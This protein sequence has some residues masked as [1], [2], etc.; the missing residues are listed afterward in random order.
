MVQ[1][2]AGTL[3]DTRIVD[4][5]LFWLKGFPDRWRL[6]EVLWRDKG[7]TERVT[8]ETRAASAAA[9]DTAAARAQAPVVGRSRELEVVTQQLLA[10][11]S[12][13][14][15]AVV[16]EG[17]AG[18]GKTRMLE[19]TA[20]LATN[21]EQQFWVLDVSADEELQGPFLLFRSLLSSP[22]MATVAREAVAGEQ[23]DAALE[24][25][26]GR[27]QRLEGL[28]PQEQMLRT[29][30]EVATTILTLTRE[31]PLLLMLDDLQWADDDSIQLIRYLVRTMG[32]A[33]VFILISLRPYSDSATGG[34]SKL[35]ADLDRMRV[36][37][38]L[39]LQR[40]TQRES[41]ELLENLL[42]APAD[43]STIESLHSRSEGVP[44]FLEEL[45]RA[46][47]EAEALQLIDGTW[48]MTKHSG[49]AVPSSIQT[50]VER[51]LAQLS[52]ECRSRLADAAV[53]GRR[54]RLADLARVLTRVDG[55]AA[56]DWQV[57]E[58]LK[59]AIDLGLIVAERP[60]SSFDFSF[61][62]DQIRTS[63]LASLPKQRRRDIHRAIA[64]QLSEAG[65]EETLS[66]LAHHAL[67]A[68]DQALA[69]SSGVRA[70]EKAM[71]MSAPEE[72]VRLIDLTLPAAS[73]PENRVEMLRIKDDALAVM[74]RSAD[75]MANLAEMAALAAAVSSPG[76]DAEIRLR[77]ASAARAN[78]DFD[79][80]IDLAQG[81]CLSAEATGDRGWSSPLVSS[82]DKR[83]PGARSER[84]TCPR[85]KP[86]ST[87]P[88]TPSGA[89]WASPANSGLAPRR[90]VP[91]ASWR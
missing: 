67:E 79:L 37:E 55:G 38:V 5:G 26:S 10:T 62:H 11:P 36:T 74:E 69:L 30:D 54:F 80:A 27:S 68:G 22:Q 48:T 7:E 31:R 58:D 51:R 90:R 17:E 14:L 8:R 56:E 49:P 33:P 41:G 13:G 20:E 91:S 81:V 35:I 73:E 78:E 47:R 66:M 16:L 52:P 3:A 71:A 1:D 6:Y 59:N 85:S 40:L 43:D 65:G 29:F 12:T 21:H 42:G 61:S 50:L 9:F 76:I 57:G 89:P 53:L 63:L 60:G 23:L 18:I 72:A 32:S 82:W 46:Y 28:S 83:S 87:P 77:R 2:L 70:A 44:F 86:T 75:R 24:A 19:A 25:I 45:A 4:R 39:R 15:R 34:A 84:A 64:E 88:E